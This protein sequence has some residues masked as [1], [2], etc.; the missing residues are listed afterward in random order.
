MC[1]YIWC[2]R[3]CMGS[4]TK[5]DTITLF[6]VC[7]ILWKS[8][9]VLN[10]TFVLLQLKTG[11]YFAIHNSDDD[12]VDD[13][14]GDKIGSLLPLHPSQDHSENFAEPVSTAKPYEICF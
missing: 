2:F 3:A 12:D 14:Y 9:N 13:W 8:Y 5:Q 10:S 6:S 11:I 1:I 4:H 7:C